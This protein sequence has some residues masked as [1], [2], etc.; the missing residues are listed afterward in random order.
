MQ[1]VV[2]GAALQ[3]SQ[4]RRQIRSEDQHAEIIGP[5]Q[6]MGESVI[7]R[8]I[9]DAALHQLASGAD[10]VVVAH[11]VGG[12]RRIGNQPGLDVA[13]PGSER[14]GAPDEAVHREPVQPFLH[15]PLPRS[16]VVP[17]LG[18]AHLG[19][20]HSATILK[21]VFTTLLGLLLLMPYAVPVMVYASLLR[22]T[23]ASP[24][25]PRQK[26][27]LKPSI[28]RILTHCGIAR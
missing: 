5:Q 14:R 1:Q 6:L 9:G 20:Q 7:G 21:S 26:L 22:S 4:R 27:P 12:H 15:W 3:P 23:R 2:A 19:S 25:P 28:L 17:S 11:R 24:T 16:G 10:F 13:P 18:S 8:Q